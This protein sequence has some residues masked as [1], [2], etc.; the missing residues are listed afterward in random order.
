MTRS[1]DSKPIFIS[2][3]PPTSLVNGVNFYYSPKD[4][5]LFYWSPEDG[6]FINV[7]RDVE[8]LISLHNNDTTNVHGII[9]TSNLAQ[10]N[11]VDTSISSLSSIYLTQEDASDTYLTQNSASSTYATQSSLD[12]YLTS[13]SAAST[14]VSQTSLST[15]L[16]DYLTTSSAS[17]TYVSQTSLSTT[18]SDYLTTSSAAS[19]YL[20]QANASS[21]YLTINSASTEYDTAE[22]VMIIAI[23]DESTN[24]TTG[25]TKLTMRAPFGMTLTKIPRASLTTASSSGN[26]TVDINVAGTSILGTNKLSIDA[27]EKTSTTAATAT[28]LT[29]TSIAD[30]VEITFDIDVSGT[31][32]KGLKVALFYKKA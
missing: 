11:Y 28:T 18:L 7:T 31:G 23:S 29:T 24:I 27:N 9:D 3:N 25:T 20:S 14:Y 32:A 4:N 1:R 5:F 12:N 6:E 15:T 26:P 21:T 10:I 2:D 17:S 8:E 19:T 13:T 30:D 22:Q 16:A